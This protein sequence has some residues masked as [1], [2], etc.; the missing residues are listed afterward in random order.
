MDEI[1]KNNKFIK[2]VTILVLAGALY[3]VG[4]FVNGLKSY[5]FIGRDIPAQT[6]INVSGTGESFAKPD[7]ANISF[8]V[9]KDAKTVSEAQKLSADGINAIM[10]YL[11]EQKIDDKDIRTT[12][13]S[14]NPKYDYQ[15]AVTCLDNNLNGYCPTGKQILIGYT[16]SQSISVKVRKIDDAGTI[17]GMLGEKGATDISGIDLQVDKK[18]SVQAEARDKAIKDA[19]AK[20]ELLA[21]SLGVSIVRVVSFSEGSNYAVPMYAKA[22]MMDSAGAAAPA[23]SIPVGQNQFTSDVTIT[24][25]IR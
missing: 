21:H 25:E 7:I 14:L 23:P 18:D 24:Y 12:N 17:I 10:A 13:Y 22:S 3:L 1:C 2:A 20:A 9:T 8:S 11:K 6:T 15:R 16:V 4:Q 5:S 19:Q